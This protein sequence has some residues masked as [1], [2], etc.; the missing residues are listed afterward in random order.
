MKKELKFQMKSSRI[1]LVQHKE[2]MQLIMT[3]MKIPKKIP[4]KNPKKI[5]IIMMMKL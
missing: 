4:K 2:M 3:M 5:K 1:Y